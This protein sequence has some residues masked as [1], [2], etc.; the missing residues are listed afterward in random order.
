L[1]VEL[2]TGEAEQ[3]YDWRK[4]PITDAPAL[5]EAAR[6]QVNELTSGK[7]PYQVHIEPNLPAFIG[8]AEYLVIVLVQLLS[9]AAKFS[10]AGQPVTSGARRAD[11][12][13]QFWVQDQ[14][15]GIPPDELAHIWEPFYQVDRAYFE[16]Q[17][18]G[19]GLAIVRSIVEMHGGHIEVAS[20]VDVGSTFTISLPATPPA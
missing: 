16:D 8:D 2:E 19:A 12:H 3:T 1:L 14:G 5:F 15:R 20:Q 17:G 13:V 4:A 10:G 9:N 7:N 11:D 18:A 6:G